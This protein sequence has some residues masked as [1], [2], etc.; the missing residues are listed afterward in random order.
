MRYYY[1]YTIKNRK[2]A[3][4]FQFRNLYLNYWKPVPRLIVYSVWQDFLMYFFFNDADLND[5]FQNK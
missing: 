2:S 3:F 4:L 1:K 5:Y